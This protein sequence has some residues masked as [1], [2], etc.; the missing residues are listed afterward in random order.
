MRRLGQFEMIY[1]R[2]VRYVHD[3]STPPIYSLYAPYP[4]IIIIVT[5]ATIAQK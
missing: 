2:F 4:Q 1:G 3:V 5:I